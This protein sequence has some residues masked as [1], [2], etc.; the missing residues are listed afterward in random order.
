M[1]CICMD[2]KMMLEMLAALVLVPAF[3]LA[4]C[5]AIITSVISARGKRI[6]RRG[7]SSSSGEVDVDCRNHN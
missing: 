6:E 4:S 2:T 1:A 7:L 5:I 3:A